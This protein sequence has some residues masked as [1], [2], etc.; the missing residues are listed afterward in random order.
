[1]KIPLIP[2]EIIWLVSLIIFVISF[3]I[4]GF[5]MLRNRKFQ[6]PQSVIFYLSLILIV[7]IPLLLD[8]TGYRFNLKHGNVEA[9]NPD[10]LIAD[11]EPR[12]YFDHDAKHLYD[13]SLR[14]VQSLSTYGQDWTIT[15]VEFD[16]EA[17]TGRISVQVPTLFGVDEFVV[18]IQ[19][20]QRVPG[21]FIP[22]WRIDIFSASRGRQY[23]FGENARHIKQFYRALDAELAEVPK[24]EFKPFK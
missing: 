8:L 23:D 16:D 11:L 4:Y 21:E 12:Q 20:V 19:S 7:L 5:K 22:S 17:D 9:T 6:I 18:G 2:W 10:G 24:Q 3:L 15:F 13:A 1:M 14:A